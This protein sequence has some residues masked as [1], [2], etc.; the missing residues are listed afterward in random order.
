[1]SKIGECRHTKYVGERSNIVL[2]S[3]TF[4]LS[5]MYFDNHRYALVEVEKR[6]AKSFVLLGI[7]QLC[8]SYVSVLYET[9]IRTGR[10]GRT[11]M[12]KEL[13][14]KHKNITCEIV[15]L[16]LNSC[17]Q[18]QMKHSAL[19][20]GIVGKPMMSY[21]LYSKYQVDLIDLQSN[22]D[23]EYKFIMVYQDHLTKFV[24]L[25]PLKIKRAEEVAYHVLSIFLIFGAPAILQSDNGREFSNQVISEMCALWKDSYKIVHGK[26]RHSQTQGS[27][28]RANQ[29]IQNMLTAWMNNDTNKWSEGLPFVQFAKNITY[30][31][32]IAKVLT[33][34]CLALKRKEA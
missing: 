8:Q 18:C 12:L 21:E 14:I 11:H 4:G 22:K 20:K 31:K 32:G 17:K 2:Q 25:R 34:P 9:H 16:H 30:H 26:L 15:M 5:P 1:M 28:E 6:G 7:S 33:K 3:C 29:N 13:Q 19:K 10:G 23:G 24:Q 27:V